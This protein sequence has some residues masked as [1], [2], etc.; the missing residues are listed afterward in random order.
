MIIRQAEQSDLKT[1]RYITQVTIWSVYPKYYPAGAVQFFS[2]HHSD[3]KI[4]A[5]I[6]KGIV[7]LLID[8]NKAAGTV[9]LHGNNICRLFVLPEHQKKGYGKALLT[10]AEKK[11][12][13][14]YDDAIL[15]ASLPA[16]AIYSKYGYHEK[17]Y[18][19]IETDNGDYL[20]YDVMRKEL[21]NGNH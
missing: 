21:E 8:D 2:G 3:E 20:C 10:F 11:I 7:Y 6:D 1:V 4:A 14:E 16:K 12:D 9:T 17:E 13:E 5:D 19:T 18:H 15:D